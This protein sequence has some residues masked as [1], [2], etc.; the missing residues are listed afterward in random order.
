M[1]QTA[2]M[3]YIG[4]DASRTGAPLAGLAFLRWLARRHPQSFSAHL[5][6]PGP[7][8]EAHRLLAPTTVQRSLPVVGR[9]GGWR[10]RSPRPS[11]RSRPALV[12]ANTLASLDAGLARRPDRLVC[13]VHE[14][15][16]VADAILPAGRRG[17]LDRVDRFVA[18]GPRVATMLIERWGIEE[19]R[20]V[21][22]D[23]FVAELPRHRDTGD[24]A[25]PG[26]RLQVLGAGSMVRRKGLDSFVAVLAA[27]G[28]ERPVPPS[29]WV[30]GGSPSPV[31]DEVRFDLAAAGL[32][33]AVGLTAEVPDLA[34]WWPAEG[35]LLH[36]PRE[37]PYPLVAIEAAH[38]AVP[39]VT[40]DTGGAADL[41]RRAGLDDLVV[42]PGDV[43]GAA[44]TVA[45]LLDHP[46][47]RLR[48]GAALAAAASDL[49]A[50][51]QAPKIWAAC[52]G[53]PQ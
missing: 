31:L 27:L 33:D 39:V 20:V 22:V 47:D 45:R 19:A 6:A 8:V 29:A 46:A 26:E 48:A 15:D 44:R 16:G 17:V 23:P 52:T 41:V 50:A 35:L 38:R 7:L 12:L 40:W 1:G 3:V 18:A 43:L 30:G 32:V 4:H 11:R 14:L 53:A 10:P 9:S 25:R 51:R 24:G 21:R 34:P 13:W 37:D 28:T 36:V 49:V 5:L 42:A 2:P